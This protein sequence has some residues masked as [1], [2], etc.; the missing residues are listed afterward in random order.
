[1]YDDGANTRVKDAEIRGGFVRVDKGPSVNVVPLL[2]AHW[3]F[4]LGEIKEIAKGKG[5]LYE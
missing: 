2:E 4:T 5:L 1:M 3:L